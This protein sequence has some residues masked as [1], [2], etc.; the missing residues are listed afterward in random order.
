MNIT[1]E[2]LEKYLWEK[3]RTAQK[4]GIVV[5]GNLAMKELGP[6]RLGFTYGTYYDGNCLC[7]LG[8]ML[9]G[10]K[11]YPSNLGL[12]KYEWDALESGFEASKNGTVKNTSHLGENEEFWLL[13]RKIAEDL[14]QEERMILLCD[15]ERNSDDMEDEM[16]LMSRYPGKM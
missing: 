14:L 4:A 9:E 8:V 15:E 2:E 12:S 1:I 6:H 10:Y 3:I 7:L 5:R 13:G 11:I 16:K